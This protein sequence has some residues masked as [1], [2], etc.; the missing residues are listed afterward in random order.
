MVET[1][2]IHNGLLGTVDAIGIVGTIFFAGWNVVMLFRALRISFDRRGG[3]HFYTPVP[4]DYL[5]ATII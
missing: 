5:G 1:G 3:D 2:N 4:A